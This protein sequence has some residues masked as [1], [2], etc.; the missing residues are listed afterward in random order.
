[1]KKLKQQAR[2]E[3]TVGRKQGAVTERD[4]HACAL[5]REARTLSAEQLVRLLLPGRSE[6]SARWLLRS[7]VDSGLLRREDA[8]VGLDEMTSVFSVTPAG[9]AQAERVAP[10]G[11][12][13]DAVEPASLAHHLALA[14]LYVQLHE[15]TLPRS[16][17][18]KRGRPRAGTSA[19]ARATHPAWRWLVG[20][21]AVSLPWREYAKGALKDRLI[22]PDAVL[23]VVGHR[24]RL[25]LEEE[26]GSHTVRAVSPDKPG[27]TTEKVKRYVAYVS[28]FVDA[29]ARTTWYQ[30]RY[31]DGFRPELVLLQPSEARCATVREAVAS[32]VRPPLQLHVWTLEAA[33]KALVADLGLKPP[34]APAELPTGRAAP[35]G[36][37]LTPAEAA[38]LKRF[39]ASARADLKA[40]QA[41]AGAALKALLGAKLS[42]QVAPEEQQRLIAGGKALYAKLRAPVVP[43]EY[44][45]VR[46]LVTRL[47][48]VLP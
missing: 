46:A 35:E 13:L 6:R 5:V 34:S 4:R 21:E 39:F 16:V 18:S 14:E 17:P 30:Q 37:S 44:D 24:R 48:A 32:L 42:S 47:G 29:N 41:D 1:M 28:G 19:F 23:E 7:L 11:I 15:A 3:V 20:G 33:V 26:T 22:R 9:D 31:A 25:F 12:S 27:A 10:G 43:E 38:A 2:S 45:A 36:L 8:W 40:R